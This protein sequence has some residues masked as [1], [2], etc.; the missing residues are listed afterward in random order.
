M[1][2]RTITLTFSQA[3]EG[4]LL[5]K[6]AEGKSPN[7]LDQYNWA[8]RKLAT[9]LKDAPHLKGAPHLAADPILDDIT[10]DHIRAFLVANAH[11]SEKSRHSIQIALSSLW[12]WSTIEGYATDHIIRPI[13]LPKIYAPDVIPFTQAEV[14]DLLKACE[15]TNSY[16]SN[17]HPAGTSNER[18]TALRDKAI[19]TFLVDTGIR[20]SELC[21]LAVADANMATRTVS[22][23]GKGKKR[24]SIHFAKRCHRALWRYHTTR[25]DHLQDDQPLFHVG[26]VDTPDP[27]ERRV[28]A[29]LLHRIGK[30]AGI[31]PANPH[32]FRHTFAIESLRNGCNLFALQD[33]LGHSSLEMVRRYARIVQ[34]D[35]AAA[36]KISSP[37]D[38]WRL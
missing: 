9:H 28:L 16:H 32:R 31:Q 12:T 21:A 26:E 18:P 23:E 35:R 38:N 30:R 10:T 22:V 6:R 11:L 13:S 34:A 14:R 20:A 3:V 27:F 4:F 29:R 7:T 37:A 5:A 33:L 19:I 1:V 2:N 36:H 25:Q 15:R 24:R 17:R 8:Y